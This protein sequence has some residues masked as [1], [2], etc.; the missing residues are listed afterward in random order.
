[1]LLLSITGICSSMELLVVVLM[2]ILV[3]RCWLVSFWCGSDM[4]LL[5][6]GVVAS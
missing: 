3:S 1:M 6:L 5:L 2:I 4:V